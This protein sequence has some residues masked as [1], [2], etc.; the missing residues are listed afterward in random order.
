MIPYKILK[1]IIKTIPM[2][3]AFA[4]KTRDV[5]PTKDAINVKYPSLLNITKDKIIIV[6]EENHNINSCFEK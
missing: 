3:F 2:G 1:T 6:K 5:T 4:Q